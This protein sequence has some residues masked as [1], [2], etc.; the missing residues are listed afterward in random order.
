[1]YSKTNCRLVSVVLNR[2][3]KAVISSCNS[4]ESISKVKPSSNIST[5]CI[6]LQQV[7]STSIFYIWKCYTTTRKLNWHDQ[8]VVQKLFVN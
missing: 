6:F 8:E 3:C 2:Q 1:M 4:T 5:S 7:L